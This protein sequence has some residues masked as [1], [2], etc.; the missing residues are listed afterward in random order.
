M[1]I[2]DLMF[3]ESLSKEELERLTDEQRV[4]WIGSR[5]TK[6]RIVNA[7]RSMA[8]RV[9][10]LVIMTVYYLYRYNGACEGTALIFFLFMYEVAY[11]L[12]RME[13]EQTD[14]LL[15]FERYSVRVE[16]ALRSR[17]AA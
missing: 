14:Y 5:P 9:T 7:K 8:V 10:L 6:N 13:K 1:E 12:L 11:Y 2:K 15:A 4:L 17:D 16:E 3:R